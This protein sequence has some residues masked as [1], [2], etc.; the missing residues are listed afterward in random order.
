MMENSVVFKP[1]LRKSGH[2]ELLV[3]WSGLKRRPSA[4]FLSTIRSSCQSRYHDTRFDVDTHDIN[5]RQT[6]T[7]SGQSVNLA[8][9]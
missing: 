9:T 6:R 3:G 4:L 5:T 1:D 2:S 7:A 8:K